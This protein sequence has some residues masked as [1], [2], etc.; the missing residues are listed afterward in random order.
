MS[1]TPRLRSEA[2]FGLV[3]VLVTALVVLILASGV[4]TGLQAASHASGRVKL[5]SVAMTLAQQ[6]QERLRAMVIGDLANVRESQTR[7]ITVCSD[8]ANT[9]C[10]DY[11]V[12]SQADW[13]GDNVGIES[14]TTTNADFD[15]LKISS[16]V[17]WPNMDTAQPVLTESLLTPRVGDVGK[18]TGN[19]AVKVVR[20]DGVTGVS[21]VGVSLAG[22]ESY[23]DVTNSQGCVVWGA[24]PAGNGY[25]VS[26]DQ[27]G[28][29]G[30]QGTQSVTRTAGVVADSLATTTILYDGAATANVAFKT[31]TVAG[32]TYTGQKTDN[33]TV[34]QNQMTPVTRVFGTGGTNAAVITAASL[35]PFK[36]SSPGGNY[37]IFAGDCDGED[38]DKQDPPDTQLKALPDLPAAQVTPYTLQIP[39]IDFTVTTQ[40]SSTA[41]PVATNAASVKFVPTT[42]GCTNRIPATW[43]PLQTATDTAPGHPKDPGIPYGTYTVCVKADYNGQTRYVTAPAA[44]E[45]L[46]GVDLG[47]INVLWNSPTT[48]TGC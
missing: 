14:C 38:P 44:V 25:T 10:I 16:K 36:T 11:T 2:G 4:L 48:T 45:A 5:R 43:T 7:T 3:E 46:P 19:L 22:P 24:L 18:N 8:A 13:V 39:S 15:Y 26:V 20:A 29:V 17:S 28:F 9:K 27:P 47:K 33:V 34:S 42:S 30:V 37:G 32:I 23:T 31:T 40:A 21:G 12:A 1:L 6:D 41:T 35:F